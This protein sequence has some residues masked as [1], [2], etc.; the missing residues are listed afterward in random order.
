MIQSNFK[1]RTVCAILCLSA[2]ASVLAHEMEMPAECKAV[3][4][5]EYPVTDLPGP[6]DLRGLIAC[7]APSL[8]Y[9][10]HDKVDFVKAR[11]CALTQ[12][13][14]T[15]QGPGILA[16]VYA[17]GQGVAKNYNLAR[18]A[19]CSAS[20]DPHE[21]VEILDKLVRVEQEQGAL[22]ICENVWGESLTAGCMLVEANQRAVVRSAAMSTLTSKW[23]AEH[24]VALNSL[25]ADL[26]KFADARAKAEVV[27]GSHNGAR[28]I[29]GLVQGDDRF[30]SLL[31]EFE[32]NQLRPVTQA[33]R[34]ALSK[35]LSAV[36]ALILKAA[37]AHPQ[38]GLTHDSLQ[39]SAKAWAEY[40]DAWVKFSK[41]RYPKVSPDT[42]QGNLLTWRVTE[43]Q[44]LAK[45]LQA[46]ASSPRK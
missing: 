1:L 13:G 28:S 32:S 11:H 36:S 16:M 22:D 18:K 46:A 15:F 29:L 41:V 25:L 45:E 8:Y 38:A 12:T 10:V 7:D 23:P 34:R 26:A 31:E 43:L 39:Q 19:A 14:N 2:S 20:D 9:G 6:K 4:S 37:K 44:R 27:Q 30:L 35:E 24:T 21:V 17:N 42:V 5:L 3:S 40:Q 33:E